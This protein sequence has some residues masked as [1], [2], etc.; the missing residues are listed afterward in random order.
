VSVGEI[1]ILNPQPNT[2]PRK[3]SLTG[4]SMVSTGMFYVY[5]LQ[6]DVD[7]GFYIGFSTNLRK[8]FAHHNRGSS[9][10]TKS[11]A[12]WKLDTGSADGYL[13]GSNGRGFRI[14]TVLVWVHLPTMKNLVSV[15]RCC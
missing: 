9:F 7:H 2:L 13:F 11:R 8:R 10:A 4:Q 14:S 5:L 3:T 12:P 6:S 1:Y 15:C